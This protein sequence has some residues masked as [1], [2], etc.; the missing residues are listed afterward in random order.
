MPFA[1]E[2]KRD[3]LA[4]VRLVVDDRH[5]RHAADCSGAIR[6]RAGRHNPATI[7]PRTRLDSSALSSSAGCSLSRSPTPAATS[8]SS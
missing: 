7:V 3:R 2:R 4:D 5:V 8:A 6:G 1:L